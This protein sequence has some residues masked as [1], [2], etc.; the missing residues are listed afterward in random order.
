MRREGMGKKV[1]TIKA[2]TIGMAFESF[3]FSMG[4]SV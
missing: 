2:C 1:S 3:F 4:R